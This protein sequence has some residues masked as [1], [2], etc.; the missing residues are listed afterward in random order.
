MYVLILLWILA[1]L[2]IVAGLAGM[3]FP[4]LPGAPVL[5]AGLII[6]AWA[7]DFVHV[8]FGTL[9]VLGV[10][11][12]L[13]YVADFLAGALGAKRF[14]A[15]RRAVIG[16]ALGAIVGLFFGLPGVL[17]GPFVGAVVGELSHRSDLRAAGRA[18]FGATI[19]LAIGIAAKL[20]LG[21]AMLGVFI[22]V[23]LL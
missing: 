17:L 16:A 18:G 4:V 10:M 11:M 9:V 22:V 20:A 23:R 21:F 12:L 5:Y 19:G 3:M 13:T 15:S 8:G 1:V 6:A 2:L 7:E 14:D